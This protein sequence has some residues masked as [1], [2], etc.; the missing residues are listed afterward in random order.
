[1]VCTAGTDASTGAVLTSE[2]WAGAAI[3]T[4]AAAKPERD[5]ALKL[6]RKE[7]DKP[8]LRLLFCVSRVGRNALEPLDKPGSSP[9]WSC[10]C[11]A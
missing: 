5:I 3:T 8:A 9:A 6:F 11:P 1:M 4:A 10:L 2:A 7:E